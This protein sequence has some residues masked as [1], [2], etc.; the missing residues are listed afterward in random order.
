MIKWSERPSEVRFLLNP[1]FCG[2]IVYATIME[3]EKYTDNSMP[4]PL[5]YL[6]L[7]LVLHRKTREKINSK[8][9]FT[10]WIQKNPQL[11]IGFAKRA[12][13]LVPITNEAIEMLL[14]T[15]K[16]FID[17]KGGL[18]INISVKRLSKTKYVDREV[19]ECIVKA[20]HVAR[21]FATTGKVEI[22]YI[23]LG[24]KP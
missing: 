6:T 18:K 10:N 21:W 12:K 13:D 20:E 14:Q 3:Y 24:V 11:L 1:A 22:I 16:I 5:V 7:P 19:K 17:R 15:H 4:F 8:T 2:R 23:N 9:A